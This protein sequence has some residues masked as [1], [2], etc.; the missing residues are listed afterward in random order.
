[1]VLSPLFLD[2]TVIHHCLISS[3]VDTYYNPGGQR[4]S[5]IN[6]GGRISVVGGGRTME[7]LPLLFLSVCAP[8]SL[9]AL[10]LI[11]H[12][13]LK[14]EKKRK[15]ISAGIAKQWNFVRH[16]F[17]RLKMPAHGAWSGFETGS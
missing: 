3:V 8:I 4:G 1:M 2:V 6:S 10:R 7:T 16:L 5:I 14:K 12:R 13:S 11:H 9:L 17:G 15:N